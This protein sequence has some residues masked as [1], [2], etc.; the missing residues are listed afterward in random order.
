MGVLAPGP[1]Q[2]WPSAQ[3]PIDTS[4]KVGAHV[5]E[6]V[7]QQQSQTIL[8][9]FRLIKQ[10]QKIGP[11]NLFSPQILSYDNLNSNPKPFLRTSLAAY[12][13]VE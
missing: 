1:A 3:P 2:A 5:L 7:G 10:Q 12:M 9:T 8:S 6:G 4:E 11:P 13:K